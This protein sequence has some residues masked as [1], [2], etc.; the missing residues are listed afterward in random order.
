MSLSLPEVFESLYNKKNAKIIKINNLNILS[1]SNEDLILILCL[2]N[3]GH[4]WK[5]LSL[6]CDIAEL[7]KSH[8][9]INWL[10]L[11]EKANNLVIKRI[12]LI[13]LYL[14][15]DLLKLKLPKEIGHEINLDESVKVIALRIEEKI[16]SK[17]ENFT[18]LSEEFSISF[19]I[20]EKKIYGVMDVI[21]G[22]II[23]TAYEWEHLH[24]PSILFP[25]Y[26]ILRPFNLLMR[27][28]F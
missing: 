8:T 23:P 24:L 9:D 5:Y 2:H 1:P 4:R 26:Y 21:N 10:K 27:Y 16:F 18:R 25:L 15:N 28:K 11:I 20:R 3:A 12:L 14:A 17:N 7:I 22:V 19:E 6:I 13:N